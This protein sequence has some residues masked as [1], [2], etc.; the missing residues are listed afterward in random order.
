MLQIIILIFLIFILPYILFKPSIRVPNCGIHAS[1]LVEG[2]LEDFQVWVR[3]LPLWDFASR[4]K[5]I[6]NQLRKD[7]FNTWKM[8]GVIGT[9]RSQRKASRGYDKMMDILLATKMKISG[10]VLSLCCGRGGWEQALAPLTSISVIRS[11]T[12]GPGLGH[13]GHEAFTD[14]PFEGRHKVQFQY[15][16]ATLLPRIPSNWVLFDG[17]E[18][19][20]KPEIEAL[21]G[22]RLLRGCVDHQIESSYNDF[23]LKVIN[24][25]H[26]DVLAYLHQLQ[27][28]TGKG[29][30]YRCSH[31]RN[32]SLEMY[33]V[34]LPRS[35]LVR[36]IRTQLH[37]VFMR[38]AT[39]RVEE[40]RAYLDEA[41]FERPAI[42]VK[43]IPLLE[44]LDYSEAIKQLG[45]ALAETGRSFAQW[46]S[47]GVYPFGYSG[48]KVNNIPKLAHELTKGLHDN[49]M[50][51]ANWMTTD[52]TP[53]GFSQ[54]FLA[55]IDIAP[56][57]DT[58]YDLHF[59]RIYEG[60]A[61][62]Y[63]KDN[64]RYR[65]LTWEETYECLNKQG[66]SHFIDV[67]YKNIADFLSR[68]DWVDIVKATRK[69][70]DSGK[71]INAIF[72]TIGKREKKESTH[73][74][75]GSRMVAF[76]PIAM[77]VLEAKIF[78]MLDTLVKPN[79]N[80]F[81]VGGVGL[82]DLG[83]LLASRYKEVAESTDIAGFDT[84]IGLK[85][86]TDEHYF[87]K[88]LAEGTS[89]STTLTMQRLYQ[90]YAYPV[91]LVP[92]PSDGFVRSELLAGRGQR[93][94]GTRPT[95]PMNSITRLAIEL[96]RWSQALG[97]QE[98]NITNWVVE[99]LG[100]KR[101]LISGMGSGDDYTS[102]FPTSYKKCFSATRDIFQQI[103][104]PRKNIP[105]NI[106]TPVT[107]EISEVEFCSHRYELVSYYQQSTGVVVKR[108]MPTRAVSE[109]IGKARVWL[110][111]SLEGGSAEAWI[112]AQANNLIVNYHHLR[113]PRALGMAY[114]A[115][116]HPNI[117]LQ[118]TG[119][120]FHR[121]PWMRPGDILEVCNRLLFGD[122]TLFPMPGFRVERL[123]HLGYLNPKKEVLYDRMGFGIRRAKWKENLYSNVS[124]LITQYNTG[125]ELSVLYQWR[126]TNL[127]QI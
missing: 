68:P 45:P 67:S 56:V 10:D 114:K 115:V 95:Y 29:A 99:T 3:V 97:I 123:S 119:F 12:I 5:A 116:V 122:S 26:P 33:F 83:M 93:M 90:L 24:P 60:L 2:M 70:L 110:G 65:E 125:G 34:S 23:I 59:K 96:L 111:G 28:R 100:E 74:P 11:Y 13:L 79:K 104:F 112:S 36:D 38:A 105:L 49:L 47:K 55:K 64:F 71:P 43:H 9:K 1:N 42:V 61:K 92:M 16:D 18:S 20:A 27:D 101:S 6:V 98:S 35:D 85:R 66:A 37:H 108:Y 44:Q 14:K 75:K 88:L 103:G 17:G 62:H 77:R 31:S 107:S 78:G 4:Y 50:G 41:R 73:G 89:S 57:E 8:Y 58:P 25:C 106:D 91:I 81:L 117:M 52:T 48:S 124:R 51:M 53:G 102:L 7:E 39:K 40:A 113:T 21:K 19:Y 54:T 82:H 118:A 46:E 87:L 15:A 76:L 121:K 120:E 72:A 30:L 109:I 86:L 63:K 84:R 126:G 69:A 32:S 22:L 94:S 127:I 80:R